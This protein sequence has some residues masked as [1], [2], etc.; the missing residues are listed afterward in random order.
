LHISTDIKAQIRT[1]AHNF[2]R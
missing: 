1:A 2:H